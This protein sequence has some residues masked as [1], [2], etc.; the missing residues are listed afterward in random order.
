MFLPFFDTLRKTGVP[1]SLREYLTF[2]EALTTELVTYDVEGFYYLARSAMVRRTHDRPL[3]SRL[4]ALLS[5]A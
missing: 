2:L 4:F 5:G 3:R 1:V